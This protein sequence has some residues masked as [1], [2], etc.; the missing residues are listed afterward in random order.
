MTTFVQLIDFETDR[1]SEMNALFDEWIAAT[2][3]QRIPTTEML[4]HDRENPRHYVEMVEFPSYEEAMRNN[5]LPETQRFA[6]RMRALC[7]SGPSFMN[8]D[9]ERRDN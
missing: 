7:T 4:M 6:E 2:E 5:D 3:G 8:L 9:L 1:A